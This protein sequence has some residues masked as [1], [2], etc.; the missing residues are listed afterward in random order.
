[1]LFVL[2]ESSILQVS[3]ALSTREQEKES[4]MSDQFL[5]SFR[6]LHMG[7]TSVPHHTETS[8]AETSGER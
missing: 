4:M 6:A 7:H 1:M 2:P 5:Q 3:T 8:I